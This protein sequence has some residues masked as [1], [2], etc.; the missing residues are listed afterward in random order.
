MLGN[1][2][3]VIQPLMP[4]PRGHHILPAVHR[5]MAARTTRIDGVPASACLL[6]T[7]MMK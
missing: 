4:S 6:P 7:E 5:P 2:G 1:L 3:P